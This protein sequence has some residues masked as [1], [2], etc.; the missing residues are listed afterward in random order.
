MAET[1]GQQL[2][3]AREA[4]NLTIQKV[5]QA[6]RIRAHHIEAIEADEFESL[7][8]PIQARAFLRL[9]VEFLGL[10]LDETIA[11][12]RAGVEGLSTTPSDIPPFPGQLSAPTNELENI[13]VPEETHAVSDKLKRFLARINQVIPGPK[14]QAAPLE[15][16]K[17]S[18]ALEP[19]E[20]EDEEAVHLDEANVP[21]HDSLPSQAIFTSIGMTLRQR[22]EGLSLTLD[23]IERHTH[24]RKHYLQALEAGEFAGLPSS[25]QARGMLS[26]YAH[27]L[28]LD[29]DTI[30][31]AFA[32]GLQTQRLE[33]QA[34]LEEMRQKTVSKSRFLSSLPFKIKIPVILRRYVSVDILVGGG[35]VVLLLTFAIWGTSRIITMSTGSTPQPTAPSILNI[36]ASSPELTTAT[37]T[38]TTSSSG[39][40]T[41]VPVA[42]ETLVLTLPAAGHGPVQVVVIAQESAWVRVTVDFIIQF[43][44]RVTSG[45][46]YP[47]DGNIQI[48]VLT[49]NGRAISIL[50]NQN[51]LGPMGNFGEVVDRI[52]TTNAILNPTATFTP[53]S[54]ISPTPTITPRPTPTLR[55]SSTPRPSATPPPSRT[56]GK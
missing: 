26:N 27:F 34:S 1:I 18:T 3:Q 5:V 15:P 55:P 8:S 19:I 7:P 10:S 46:A 51:N 2:K 13:P 14:V 54:T 33:R 17:A 43:E 29:V 32:E 12:Q 42:G 38:L 36:L 21:H 49:G 24:V 4:K 41:N 45:T 48:E 22:R 44:G 47:F 37:P 50:Y 52:Y 28:N 35:L 30:L 6:T 16:A 11:R 39:P 53:T 56:P 31:L 20:E 25:V 9:Y 23:E 40:V